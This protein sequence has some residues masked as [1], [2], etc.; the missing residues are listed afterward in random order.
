MTVRHRSAAAPCITRALTVAA[1]VVSVAPTAAT[2]SRLPRFERG[3]CP[4]NGDWARELQREC[5]WLVVSESRDRPSANTL[6][7]AVEIFRAKEPSGAPPLV[8][9]HGGPG[10]PGGIR[11]YSAGVAMSALPRRRDVVIYDQRGAGFSEPKL[12]PDYDRAVDAVYNQ[13]EGAGKE[14]TLRLARRS[15][16]AELDGK[17][18]DRLAYNTA[19]SVADLI[20][21]RR[22]LGFTSW[23]IHGGSYGAR[24]AQEAMVRDG[25]AIRAVV[26]ASPVARGL[27]NQSLNPRTTQGAFARMFAARLAQPS[28]RHADP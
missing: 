6:R 18:I 16:V 26:L 7:L 10:G 13:R 21:L 8:I 27:S 23:D 20:D 11:L 22:V 19:A 15:C 28:G 25:R 2:Q 5:G 3:E 4:V 17:R 14:T 24:L 12:C 1:L 9:L